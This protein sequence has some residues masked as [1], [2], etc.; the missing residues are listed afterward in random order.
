MAAKATDHA[1]VLELNGKLRGIVDE[2][3]TL[4]MEWL[5]LAEIVG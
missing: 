5:E 4:E 3:E 1:A 2:R